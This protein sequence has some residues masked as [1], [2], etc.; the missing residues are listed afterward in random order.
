MKWLIGFAISC[1]IVGIG[2]V[3]GLNFERGEK[4]SLV[5]FVVL[6]VF[7]V[8]AFAVDG[9]NDKNKSA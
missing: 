8:I 2:W 1:G 5:L 3:S 9:P 4:Q 7:L 6:S